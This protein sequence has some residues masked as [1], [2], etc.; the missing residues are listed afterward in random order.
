MHSS[1]ELIVGSNDFM[2]NASNSRRL[3]GSLSLAIIR[4]LISFVFGQQVSRWFETEDL[5]ER[6]SFI[7]SCKCLIV[8]PM[9][10]DP[11][12]AHFISYTTPPMKHFLESFSG[13][14]L[15]LHACLSTVS[16]SAFRRVCDRCETLTLRSS[17]RKIFLSLLLKLSD[18]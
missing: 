9:Y 10:L 14:L 12:S 11:H 7:L 5:L 16:L 17:S 6:C 8:L 3:I 13:Q 4:T 2:Y 1:R 18:M 15:I